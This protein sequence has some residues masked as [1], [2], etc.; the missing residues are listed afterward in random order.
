MSACLSIQAPAK[1]RSPAGQLLGYYLKMEPHLF[2][3][4]VEDEFRKI[5]ETREAE[6][7]AKQSKP[8]VEPSDKS[9]LVLYK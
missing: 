8:E 5:K 1:P 4:A 7:K 9:E 2:K 3:A 6:E